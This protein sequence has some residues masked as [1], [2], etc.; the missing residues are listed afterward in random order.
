M[1]LSVLG[2]LFIIEQADGCKAQVPCTSQPKLALY[3]DQGFL[4]SNIGSPENPWFVTVNSDI[5]QIILSA[6]RASIIA[7]YATFTNL[8]FSLP[9]S[10]LTLVYKIEKPDN[11]NE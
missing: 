5:N 3:D 2:G 10:N 1:R 4:A 11:I 8:T 6:S 9:A 7:G